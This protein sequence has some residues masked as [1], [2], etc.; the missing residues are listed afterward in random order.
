MRAVCAESKRVQALRRH[1]AKTVPKFPNT[2]EVRDDFERKPLDSQLVH[3]AHWAIRFVWPRPRT[4]VVDASAESD[5]RWRALETQIR[6]VLAKAERGDDLTP[7]LPLDVHSR[8]YSPASGGVGKEVDLWCDKDF[9]LTVAGY[10]HFHLGAIG[11]K[12]FAKRTDEVL[13]ARVDRERF[14]VLGLF[15]HTVFEPVSGARDRMSAEHERLW[16]LIEARA[17]AGLPPGA[18]YIVSPITTSGHNLLLV[19]LAREYA[20]V[21]YE[22][23]P[24]LD[25]DMELVESLYEGSGHRPPREPRFSWRLRFLDLALFERGGRFLRVLRH[26]PQ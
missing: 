13:F 23:D 18:V 4:V 17:S 5:P 12:G 21:V 19:D 11:P 6:A 2:R 9:I 1:I 15:D 26:G 25:A 22:V 3:Y 8:A 7:H 16:S 10:H 24:K 14:E 20:R